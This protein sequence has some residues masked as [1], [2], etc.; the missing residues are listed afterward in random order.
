LIDASHDSSPFH[1]FQR[2]AVFLSF[3]ESFQKPPSRTCSPAITPA[4]DHALDPDKLPTCQNPAHP[5]EQV[6]LAMLLIEPFFSI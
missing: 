4:E 2:A 3:P 5:V 6:Y 1:F